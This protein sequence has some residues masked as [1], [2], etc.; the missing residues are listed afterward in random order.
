MVINDDELPASCLPCGKLVGNA[1]KIK[2]TG[3]HDNNDIEH[4]TPDH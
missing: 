2:V 3:I 4:L 1:R